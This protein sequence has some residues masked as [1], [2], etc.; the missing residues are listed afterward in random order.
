MMWQQRI[1]SQYDQFSNQQRKIADFLLQHPDAVTM[2]TTSA[3]ARYATTS[4]ATVSRLC[5]VLGYSGWS[6]LQRQAQN[7][8]FTRRAVTKA[9]GSDANAENIHAIA[10]WD[11]ALI[12]QLKDTLTRDRIDA[13]IG[14]VVTARRV[15]V[16]AARSSFPLA[17]YLG[18][19]LQVFLRNTVIVNSG[20]QWTDELRQT[21][22]DDVL[23]LFFFPRYSQGSLDLARFAAQY[24]IPVVLITDSGLMTPRIESR[25]VFYV[26]VYTPYAVDSK[27]AVMTFIHMFLSRLVVLAKDRVRESLEMFEQ[28]AEDFGLF[29][30]GHQTP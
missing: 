24:H 19:Y 26:P 22:T 14:Q 13:A 28:T 3:V 12:D 9:L 16:A 7:D 11:K 23:I 18:H 8:V 25:H 5:Q 6:E 27:V 4:E 1:Q 29:S 20:G 21:Q 17:Q 10:E 30:V 15:V 2:M